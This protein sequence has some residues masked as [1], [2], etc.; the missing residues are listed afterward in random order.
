MARALAAGP[1][2]LRRELEVHLEP[3]QMQQLEVQQ[4]EVQQLEVQ[5]EAV[6]A[7]H[8]WRSTSLGPGSLAVVTPGS[9]VV[10]RSPR[11]RQPSQQPPQMQ[12]AWQEN[13]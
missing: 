2:L 10:T 12:P 6:F 5:E 13:P 3:Q 7:R 11:S 8:T 9:C 1:T 4:L